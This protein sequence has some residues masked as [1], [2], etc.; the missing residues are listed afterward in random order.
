MAHDDPGLR[1]GADWTFSANVL[2]ELNADWAMAGA[3]RGSNGPRIWLGTFVSGEAQAIS[4]H[5]ARRFNINWVPQFQST[6]RLPSCLIPYKPSSLSGAQYYSHPCLTV[7]LHAEQLT[8]HAWRSRAL[9]YGGHESHRGPR[10]D[11]GLFHVCLRCLWRYLLRLRFGVYQR[12]SGYELLHYPVHGHA[13]TGIVS[14]PSLLLVGR[15]HARS[16]PIIRYRG[17]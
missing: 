11:E 6:Y 2:W 12:C 17:Y 7:F 15:A 9:R 14:R 5:E 10:L 4:L 1:S 16:F 13:A 8:H 3:T